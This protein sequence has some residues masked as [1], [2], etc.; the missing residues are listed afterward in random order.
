MCMYPLTSKCFTTP[1]LWNNNLRPSMR[2]K[3]NFQQKEGLIIF[4]P[5]ELCRITTCSFNMTEYEYIKPGSM[6]KMDQ[7]HRKEGKASYSSL[8]SHQCVM[9][10]CNE[11]L[12]WL[13]LGTKCSLF[14]TSTVN[15]D[16][17]LQ[18]S[19]IKRHMA[20]LFMVQLF[21][22]VP[23]FLPGG[24]IWRIHK[25]KTEISTLIF[26]LHLY[27]LLNANKNNGN[28]VLLYKQNKTHL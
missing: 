16:A 17:V 5:F 20:E 10:N 1:T 18:M 6:L 11:T 12:K 28:D 2:T 19:I 9:R 23:T 22:S 4:A 15:S 26:V 24:Q 3:R 7:R 14:S 13:F 21:I 8:Y 27:T 25:L